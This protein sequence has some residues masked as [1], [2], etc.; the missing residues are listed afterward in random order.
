M[1]TILDK[2]RIPENDEEIIVS[3]QNIRKVYRT[4]ASPHHRLKEIAW[5]GKRD[6][7]KF[8]VALDDVTLELKRGDRLG[9]MGENGSGKSTL[10]KI[11]S[12]VLTPSSG[13]VMVR[14]RIAALLELGAGF[15]FD[16]TGRENIRQYC[17][18]HGMRSAEIDEA[19]EEIIDFSELDGAID[20]PVKTYSSGM[21]IRLGFSCAVYSRPDILIVDEAL[22]VG[23]AYFQNKCLHKIKYL[24]DQGVTFIYVSHATDSV[25]SLC[26]RG[27]WLDKGRIRMDG[28]SVDIA[29]AYQS[30]T[31]SRMVKAGIPTEPFS[32]DVK[33]GEKLSQSN[34]V[35]IKEPSENNALLPNKGYLASFKS[36]LQPLRTGSAEIQ[37][38]YVS[39]LN[40]KGE[41]T[42]CVEYGERFSIR[43]YF[44]CIKEIDDPA[45]LGVSITDARGVD[46]LHFSSIA[47]SVFVTDIDSQACAFIELKFDNPLCPGTYG[48]NT[49]IGVL[50]EHPMSPARKI[51][52]HVIDYCPGAAKIDILEPAEGN[53]HNLWGLVSIDYSLT[54]EKIS[55]LS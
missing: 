46:L 18:L 31:F 20:R 42:D 7:A 43:I 14:G 21:G 12:G 32:G 50:V 26:D 47:K 55:T 3:A 27:V 22:S 29:A 38:Q 34:D 15:H 45:S 48:I 40:E 28:P 11:L 37:I 36:R 39:V 13:D 33:D 1:S 10:L 35:N 23:D 44:E 54:L 6:Y 5:G 25:R 30:E 17:Q 9:I 8:S 53:G 51:I 52:D 49:G 4:Y 41:E 2:N 16:L 19:L 24:L